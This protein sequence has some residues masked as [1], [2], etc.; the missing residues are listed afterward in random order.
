M[1]GS[2]VKG[3]RNQSRT[4]IFTEQLRIRVQGTNEHFGELSEL[5][6]NVWGDKIFTQNPPPPPPP[7]K[8]TLWN[9][10]FDTTLMQYLPCSTDTILCNV[11]GVKCQRLPNVAKPL[12][13]S[14]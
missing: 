13:T 5:I 10:S 6:K 9:I 12:E 3:Q 1:A 4:Y 14:T 8:N 2:G 11:G 7:P